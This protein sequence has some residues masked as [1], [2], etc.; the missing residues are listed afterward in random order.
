MPAV[1]HRDHCISDLALDEWLAGECDA[2]ARA[3]LEGHLARCVRCRLQRDVIVRERDSF[4]A[5]A[6]DW[7][8]FVARRQAGQGATGTA[9]TRERDRTVWVASIA[10]A[11][12]VLIGLLTLEERRPSERIKGGPSIGVFLKRGESVSR[13]SSGERVRAGDQL[14]IVYSSTRPMYFA[15]LHRDAHTV[16]IHFP[17]GTHST[18]VAAGNEVALD[19]GIRLDAAPGIEELIGLF[20]TKPLSLERVR[21]EL[22]QGSSLSHLPECIVD[23]VELD[24]AAARE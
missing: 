17:L 13:A 22:E 4:L 5:R 8:S 3:K 12:S 20:C 19:F 21:A 10:L 11:A 16:S 23:V 2:E 18:R 6:P 9:P 1:M 15:L 24:K 7:R 14:R